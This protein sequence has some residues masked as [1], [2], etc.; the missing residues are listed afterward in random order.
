VVQFARPDSDISAGGWEPQGSSAETTLW[1]SLDE[2]TADDG[3]TYIEAL[4]GENITCEVGLSNITD[5]GGNTGY[6][7]RFTMQGTGSGGPE[8]CNIELFEGA[9]VRADTGSQTSRAAWGAKSYELTTGE[10]DA[11]T[12][13]TDLRL[14]ITSSN[15]GGSEDM[16]VTQAFFEVPDVPP[17]GRLMSS[18]AGAGGLAGPGGIAGAGGGLAG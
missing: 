14:K 5:P 18:L 8:R 10:A 15:L 13:F 6:F 12:A 9:T 2:V 4:D 16:W 1:E 3:V 17:S 7:I 11:I